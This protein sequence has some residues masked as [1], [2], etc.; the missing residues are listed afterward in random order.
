VPFDGTL[1]S[2]ALAGLSQQS[3]SIYLHVPFCRSRC[4][5][6]DFNT[7]TNLSM[8]RG[9]SAEDFVGTLA[10][11]LLIG[12]DDAAARYPEL[13]RQNARGGQRVSR[14]ETGICDAA[15]QVLNDL[16]RNGS[17]P[18]DLHVHRPYQ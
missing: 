15:A 7:Y 11:E 6:C 10:G 1:P 2:S 14:C 4:G 17:V 18:V 12:A 8:G 16:G 13:T 5:Y 9:A 3:L